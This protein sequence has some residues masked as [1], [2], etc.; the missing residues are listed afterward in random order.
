VIRLR[1]KPLET[2]GPVWTGDNFDEA[3]EFCGKY[4]HRWDHQEY[5]AFNDPLDLGPQVWNSRRDHWEHLSP[6]DVIVR[7]AFGEL[8]SMRA[9][10]LR[11]LYD[12][13]SEE[14]ARDA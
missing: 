6:G 1:A 11:V 8:E 2:T 5:I 12:E 13:I 4:R 10:S 3:R 9:E 7:G 14:G